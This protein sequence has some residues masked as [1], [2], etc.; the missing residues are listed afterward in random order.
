MSPRSTLPLLLILVL[1]LAGSAPV[2]AAENERGPAEIVLHST[3]DPAR[4]PRPAFFPHGIH[5]ENF[6]CATCHHSQ[7]D[8]GRQAPYT[9]GMQVYRCES[10]HNKGSDTMP[11]ELNT[12]KKAAHERCRTC[13]KERKKEGLK[14]GPTKCTGCHRKDLK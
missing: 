8:E 12:F 13:H 7:D 2:F 9:E 10:C 3:I 6:D 4:K 1:V 5:Q 14:A 11:D